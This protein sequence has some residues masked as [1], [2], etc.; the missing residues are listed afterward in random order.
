[1]R[2]MWQILKWTGAALLLCLALL[3]AGDYVS[4]RRR[5]AHKTA[6][7][8]VE[9][10]NVRPVYAIARKDGKDEFDVGDPEIQ[11][12]VHALF[13]HLGYNPCWY[14]KREVQKPIQID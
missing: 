1:M 10:I 6:A 2:M 3:W 13:P 9:T 5:M 11:S 8:P 12:C 4:V 14:V 7:D